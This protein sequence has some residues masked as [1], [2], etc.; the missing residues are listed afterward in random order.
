M[1]ALKSHFHIMKIYGI[2]GSTSVSKERGCALA[3]QQG[4]RIKNP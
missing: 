3:E 2:I 4:G 1:L